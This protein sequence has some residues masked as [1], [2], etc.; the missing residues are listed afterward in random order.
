LLVAIGILVQPIQAS[1]PQADDFY[2]AT[3][4][5]EVVRAS[6]DVNEGDGS[7][8]ANV[9]QGTSAYDPNLEYILTYRC[10]DASGAQFNVLIREQDN[11]RTLSVTEITCSSTG[12]NS[13]KIDLGNKELKVSMILEPLGNSGSVNGVNSHTDTW[14]V[15][16]PS[17]Y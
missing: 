9:T 3:F 6:F 8:G 13:R 1:S 7:A 17:S 12:I 4:E 11:L 14:V 2:P 5:E 16:T 10:R 15:L